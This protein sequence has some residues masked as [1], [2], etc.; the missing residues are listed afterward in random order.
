MNDQLLEAAR[1][2]MSAVADS[3][4]T[5]QSA[6]ALVGAV[7]SISRVADFIADVSY[8]INLLALNATIEAAR[9]GEMGRG[10]A[11]VAGEVKLLA[12]ATSNAAADIAQQLSAVK[13][14]TDQVVQAIDVT[15]DGIGQIGQMAGA[16]EA[17]HTQKESATR[18]IMG[19]V[20]SV[21]SNAQ[22]VSSVIHDVSQ[23]TGETQRVAEV[24]LA[25]T[26]EL[27]EQA[28]RL[29]TRSYEFCEKIAVSEA[30]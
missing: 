14:A 5:S 2:A 7:D 6:H 28:E 22:H 24:M 19:C 12:R 16:L 26:L 9:C 11:V 4:S 21:V 25:A 27:S 23:S 13:S 10:F 15:V 8:K 20:N 29:L 17:A 1:I 18:N 30:A 3:R